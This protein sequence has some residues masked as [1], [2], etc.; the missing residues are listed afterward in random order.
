MD[1]LGTLLGFP[2]SKISALPQK[3][4]LLKQFLL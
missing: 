3:M 4:E 1:E 2:E